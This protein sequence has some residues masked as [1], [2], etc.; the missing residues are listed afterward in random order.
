MTPSIIGVWQG[1]G[2]SSRLAEYL[3]Q[4]VDTLEVVPFD[5][6]G[7]KDLSAEKVPPPTWLPECEAHG[8]DQGENRGA[9]PPRVSP[10]GEDQ[11]PGGR[12]ISVP[13]WDGAIYRANDMI[14]RWRKGTVVTLGPFFHST[15]HLL[16]NAPAG[17]KHF[18]A[19][20]AAG[21]AFDELEKYLRAEA[22]EGRKISYVCLELPS[23]TPGT[24][25]AVSRSG[26]APALRANST[27]WAWPGLGS[28]V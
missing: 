24:A 21:K 4:H 2:V 28:G 27:C 15:W 3:L 5:V 23:T 7:D 25:C 22:K 10:P 6:T 19:C 13:E 14:M 18:V 12:R 8:K 20:E 9:D 26:S 17:F 11:G 1:T 16:H